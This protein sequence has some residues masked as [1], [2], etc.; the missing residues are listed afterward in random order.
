MKPPLVRRPSHVN[1]FHI[2]I[3][4]LNHLQY[5]PFIP[6]EMAASI[7]LIQS[8]SNFY[9]HGTTAS[10]GP[11]PRHYRGFAIRH[12]TVGGTPL[13]E[14][15]DRHRDLYMTTHNTHKR[16]ISA[17]GIQTHNPSK[18]ATADLRLRPR[19]QRDRSLCFKCGLQINI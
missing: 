5:Y 6:G 18:R 10:S 15:S 7:S 4:F 14:R 2:H 19:G 17:G 9:F 8:L 3:H 16:D 1:Q 12:T 11:W 13:D